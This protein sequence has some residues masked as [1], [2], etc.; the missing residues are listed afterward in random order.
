MNETFP[1]NSQCQQSPNG[2]RLVSD[3]LVCP[4][5]CE[6]MAMFK[7]PPEGGANPFPENEGT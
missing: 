5:R 7:E 3:G 1:K 2:C 4:D 6:W